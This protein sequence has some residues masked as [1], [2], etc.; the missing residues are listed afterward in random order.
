M[1]KLSNE[2]LMGF[3]AWGLFLSKWNRWQAPSQIYPRNVTFEAVLFP[4][5][6]LLASWLSRTSDSLTWN[7]LTF[8]QRLAMGWNIG[9]WG[10]YSRQKQDI[11]LITASRPALRPTHSPV[12]WLPCVLSPWGKA[13][14]AWSWQ[15]TS[16]WYRG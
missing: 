10:Y 1:T 3:E 9:V 14:G 5:R 13:A 7:C 15:L 4:T 12:Q 6:A 11:F 8:L 2:E 16:I